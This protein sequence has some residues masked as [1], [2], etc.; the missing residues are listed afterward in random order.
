MEKVMEG[1]RAWLQG[2]KVYILLVVAAVFNIGVAAGF[3]Q[4]DSQLWELVNL[5]FS[6]LGIGAFR[7]AISKA[8]VK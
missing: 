6:F 7:S 2:K 3:W 8:E 1:I 5:I 4:P